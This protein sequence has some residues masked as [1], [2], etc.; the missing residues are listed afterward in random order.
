ML[1]I[2]MFSTQRVVSIIIQRC[3]CRLNHVSFSVERLT[4]EFPVI[5]GPHVVVYAVNC[6]IMPTTVDAENSQQC[7]QNSSKFLHI[8][9]SGLWFRPAT[10]P[11][12]SRS[13]RLRMHF[14]IY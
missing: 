11:D 4:R 14:R 13:A 9:D 8:M 5:S 10:T 1:P 7:N 6:I 2:T 3:M 12:S